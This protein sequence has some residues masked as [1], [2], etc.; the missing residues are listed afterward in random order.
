MLDHNNTSPPAGASFTPSAKAQ[1]NAV[2]EEQLIGRLQRLMKLNL[3]N[4]CYQD[5]IFFADKLLH[6]SMSRGGADQFIKAVYDLAHC[7]LMN[8]ENLRC[9]QLI[10]K[11]E[12]AF[13]SEQFRIITA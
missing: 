9:V 12:M 6:L 11:Y 2:T 4:L 1:G 13:H 8:K 7:Y 5:A 10:E 3:Q